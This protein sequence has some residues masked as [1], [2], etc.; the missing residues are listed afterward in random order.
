MSISPRRTYGRKRAKPAAD[1]GPTWGPSR[2]GSSGSARG[3]RRR[4]SEHEPRPRWQ[5]L[6]QDWCRPSTPA[7]ALVSKPF[8]R[9]V[10]VIFFFSEGIISCTFLSHRREPLGHPTRELKGKGMYRWVSAAI[11]LALIALVGPQYRPGSQPL[12]EPIRSYYPNGELRREYTLD[13]NG[14]EHGYFRDWYPDGSL[15][16]EMVI[17]HGTWESKREWWPN[18]VL[19]EDWS[20]SVFGDVRA[21]YDEEGRALR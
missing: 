4:R 3:R 8:D 13:A 18:G 15:A 21:C 2:R 19:R 6:S 10:L 7:K 20:S 9:G 12:A 11:V 16:R 1:C 17:S 5:G 14:R